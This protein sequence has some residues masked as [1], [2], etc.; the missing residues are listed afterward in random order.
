M[1]K[2]SVK[3]IDLNCLISQ[4]WFSARWV[5]CADLRWAYSQMWNTESRNYLGSF[6]HDSTISVLEY[7]DPSSYFPKR[8]WHCVWLPAWQSH[9]HDFHPFHL[10]SVILLC[11][12]TYGNQCILIILIQHFNLGLGS[13]GKMSAG[14]GGRQT[15]PSWLHNWGFEGRC[16]T[17]MCTWSDSISK[18]AGDAA[19]VEVLRGIP[20]IFPPIKMLLFYSRGEGVVWKSG[21]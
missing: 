19:D 10:V 16:K 18:A 5:F 12:F 6:R 2:L 3:G 4:P 21:L 20:L 13:G 17:Q 15:G 8:A 1:P 14:S 7:L 9:N 11:K